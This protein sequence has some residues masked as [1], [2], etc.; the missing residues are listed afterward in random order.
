M[1][2]I[3]AL[4]NTDNGKV[5][6]GQSKN[7]SHRKSCHFSDLVCKKHSNKSLSEDYE[8]NPKSIVF[9]ILCK[10]DASDLN[11]LEKYYIRKFNSTDPNCGYNIEGG[12]IKNKIVSEIT[13]KK[14]SESQKGNKHMCGIKLSEE[15]KRHLG[16]AQPHRKRILCTE[17]GIIYDSFADAAR[18]TGLTRTKIVSVCTGHRKS[19]GGLH[20]E[21]Y[22]ETKFNTSISE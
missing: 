3:Y 16:E 4:R 5:Y 7:L 8:K 12:G 11:D 19:T 10:C 17:T 9:E 14:M 13:K 20:F 21:Y 18:K 22:D 1:V 2:G 15:W 6:I